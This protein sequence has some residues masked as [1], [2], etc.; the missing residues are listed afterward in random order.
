MSSRLAGRTAVAATLIVGLGVAGC[1]GSSK[2]TSSSTGSNAHLSKAEFLKRG[3]AICKR[4]NDR[5]NA[6]G[7]KL[8]GKGHKRPTAAQQRQFTQSAIAI[9]QGEINGVRGLPAP[10][11]DRAR[12]N[13]IADAAQKDLDKVKAH[14]ALLTS[15]K[16]DPFKDAN[17]L[18]NAYGLTACGSGGG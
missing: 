16:S 7:N 15:D 8:F 6:E 5:L 17:K 9:I 4:G 12:I 2:S 1:G 18:S 11:G 14:P 3:N 10:T 13:K